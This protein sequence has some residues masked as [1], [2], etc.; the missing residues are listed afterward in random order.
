MAYKLLGAAVANPD[1]VNIGSAT[2]VH[3]VASAA[4][5]LTVRKADESVIG[6]IRISANS[7]IDVVKNPTDTISCL[8]SICTPIAYHW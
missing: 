1:K 5:T 3:V 6:E 7:S 4:A 8:T 2:L